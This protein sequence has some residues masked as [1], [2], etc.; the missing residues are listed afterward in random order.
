MDAITPVTLKRLNTQFSSLFR[1]AYDATPVW[2]NQ[3]A[4]EVPSSTAS[5]TYGW[6]QKLITLSEWLTERTVK[7]V[8]AHSYQIANKDWE[9][10]IAVDRNDIED[11][12]LGIYTSMVVPELGLAARKHPDQLMAAL[13]QN[14]QTSLCYDGQF[15]FDTDHPIGPNVAGTQSNYDA[16]SKPLTQA[17][18]LDVRAKMMAFKGEDNQPLSIVP[19]LLVVPP[20]LEGTARKILESEL[21]AEPQSATVGGNAVTGTAGVSNVTRGMGRVLVVPELAGADTTWYLLA[22][23]RPIK[24]FVLQMRKAPQF[25]SKTA[26]TDDN[27]FERKQFLYGVDGRWNAGYALWFLAYKAVG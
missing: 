7:N 17:N 27:V 15:F 16:S 12:N 6:M 23:S 25:I 10:T 8:A 26:A 18:F 2:W 22:T 20:A 5:N 19:D 14:G 13:L 21:I 3:V 9:G 24:P 4:T 1:T 11:D